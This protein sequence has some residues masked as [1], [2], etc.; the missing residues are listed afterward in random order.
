MSGHELLIWV[1]G[2]FAVLGA[3]DRLLG[4]RFGLGQG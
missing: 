2:I 4:D 1:M 3:V